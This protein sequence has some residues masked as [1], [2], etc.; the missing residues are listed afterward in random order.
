MLLVSARGTQGKTCIRKLL[1]Y[2]AESCRREGWAPQNAIVALNHPVYRIREPSSCL[3]KLLCGARNVVL[4]GLLN[5]ATRYTAYTCT[6][7]HGEIELLLLL[8]L[9]LRLALLW[10]CLLM[11]FMPAF[12]LPSRLPFVR[13]DLLGLLALLGGTLRPTAGTTVTTTLPSVI[14]T[15]GGFHGR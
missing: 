9:L 13:L 5:T 14:M 15:T 6:T 4:T 8:R 1:A 3:R 2:L 10:P 7:K 12:L 11:P